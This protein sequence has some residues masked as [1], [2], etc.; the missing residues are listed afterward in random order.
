MDYVLY[1]PLAAGGTGTAAALALREQ[2]ADPEFRNLLE[3][4]SQAAVLAALQPGDRLILCGGD[5]TLNRFVNELDAVPDE[6]ILYYATG[7]GND[8]L[9]DIGGA[10]G[11]GP[12]RINPYL[13]NLPTVL[14][15]GQE[16]RFLNGI[17]YGIDGY[18]CQEGDR[19]RQLGRKPDYT[20]IAVRG[21]LFH[22]RPVN[23]VVTVDGQSFSYQRVWLAPVMFGRYYG[24]GMMPA[25][26]Q[27]RLSP[28]GTVSVMIFHG[29]GKL[30]S[31][32][33]FPSIF[34][35][36]HVR[37]RE[38]VQVLEGSRI[39]V[40]FDRPTPLQID[41]ET[42]PDVLEYQVRAPGNAAVRAVG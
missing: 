19:L 15:N 4:G 24:G 41:G 40:R 38:M 7:S 26:K 21:L 10:P 31:L 18:C 28:R 22:Y 20:A 25:P 30:K 42:V 23:A 34:K 32:A 9:R 36:G 27:S 1:N 2:L 37:R 33:V 12:V 3:P 11:D 16:R 5:G 39:R 17:G 13:R 8:F 35:G 29:A 6:D 14:V